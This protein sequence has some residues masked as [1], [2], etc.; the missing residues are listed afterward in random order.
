MQ[1]LFIKS[2]QFFI[3]LNNYGIFIHI[4]FKYLKY[5]NNFSLQSRF[6]IQG[7]VKMAA[8]LD[9]A[10]FL[11]KPSMKYFHFCWKMICEIPSTNWWINLRWPF[12]FHLKNFRHGVLFV[13]G[14][15]K[16]DIC[17]VYLALKSFTVSPMYSAESIDAL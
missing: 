11:K 10:I 4:K 17:W 13:R 2:L 16:E 14:Y 7:V 8:I 12:F 9:F 5:L 15:R 1:L 6:S 3:G